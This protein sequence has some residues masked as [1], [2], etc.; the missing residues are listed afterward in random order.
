MEKTTQN[1]L[2]VEAIFHE[3]TAVP[4]DARAELV[5]ALSNG[6]SALAAEVNSLLKPPQQKRLNLPPDRP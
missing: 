4:L 3:A 2:R 1:L 5:A 6:D